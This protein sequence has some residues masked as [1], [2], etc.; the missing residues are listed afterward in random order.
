[1]GMPSWTRYLLTV[2]AIA[3]CASLVVAQDV[4]EGAAP[5]SI[6]AAQD[7]E[8]S[9]APASPPTAEELKAASDAL[10]ANQDI[11]EA[12]RATL[13]D[14]YSKTR[15]QLGKIKDA[16][17]RTARH[18]AGAA[19]AP[20][21]LADVRKKLEAPPRTVEITPDPAAT[22]VDLEAQVK[23][24]NEALA[25][26]RAQARDIEAEPERRTRRRTEIPAELAPLQRELAELPSRPESAAGDTDA[27]TV[28]RGWLLAAQ[29]EALKQRIAAR[30]A[31]L[32]RYD[33]TRDL[34]AAL[35][36]AAQIDTTTAE[37]TAAAW[38]KAVDDRRAEARDA[39]QDAQRLRR[40]AARQHAV[41]QRFA[42]DTEALAATRTGPTGLSRKLADD[43][44]L[45]RDWRD[46]RSRL[47]RGYESIR[48]RL[49]PDSR[50]NRATGLLLRR[51]AEDLPS[52]S[53]LKNSLGRIRK[54]LETA[55]FGLLKSQ[56]DRTD[57]GDVEAHVRQLLEEIRDSDPDAAG[58]EAEAVA[59]ELV[60]A[61]RDL[62]DG[63]VGNWDK[64]FKTLAELEDTTRT[65]IE[66]TKEYD[67]FI[68]ERIL[69]VKSITTDEM[70]T[71]AQTIE[72]FR[73]LVDARS[74]RSTI[75]ASLA[76]AR[77]Y[78]IGH[79][80]AAL[81]TILLILMRMRARRVIIRYA[82]LVSNYRTDKYQY[83]A[84][85]FLLT[86]L[87]A[88]LVPLIMLWAAWFIE[89][90]GQQPRIAQGLGTG[91]RRAA[92]SLFL[93]DVL[94]IS[95]WPKGLAGAHFRWPL[96]P[97]NEIRRNLWWFMILV[98]P[99]AVV[100]TAV[101]EF[102]S[103][104]AVASIGRAMFSVLLILLT[105]LLQ[106]I[107]RP[108]GA[109]VRG[110]AE[111]NPGGIVDRLRYLW[112]GLL[113]ISP[114]VLIAFAW[115]GYL[116]TAQQLVRH[117][118]YSLMFIGLVV[119]FDGLMHRWLFIARRRV[120]VENARRRREEE[121]AAE[122]GEDPAREVPVA[123]TE[124]L[125]LPAISAH[126]KHPF[127]TVLAITVVAGLFCTWR[128]VLP[129]LRMFDR[130]QVYPSFAIVEPPTDGAQLEAIAREPLP[131][132]ETEGERA[133]AAT[134]PGMP[135]PAASP[136]GTTAE[137]EALTITIADLGGAVIVLIVT[138]ILFRNVPG[139]VDII[140]LQRLPLEAGSRY[141]LS[142]VLR[143]SIAIVGVIVAFGS[144]G[145]AWSHVQWLAAALTFGLAFGLQEIFANFV[146]GLIILGEQPFRV[147]DT[148]TVGT[149]SGT[150]TKIKM[151][152]TTIRDW[153]RKEIVIPN[154]TFITGEVVNWTL[155]DPLL[156]LIIEVGV[157]YGSDTPKVTEVLYGVARSHPRVLKDPEPRVHFV[158][159][160]DSTLNFEMRI[161]ISDIDFMLA[162][163]HEV[164]TAIA[165]RFAEEGIEI[166]F[167]Q[168]DLH[169]R[170]IGDL[171]QIVKRE[172]L[173]LGE[174]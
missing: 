26:A 3:V 151:R 171:A 169:V 34:L 99:G 60:T 129:A 83:T 43:A 164:N 64:Y 91:L 150:V 112:T 146:S 40:E 53:L 39:E 138:W 156:R 11:D 86:C 23:L 50:L 19:S 135:A 41:L 48:Q 111:R 165:Q 5:A 127:E 57:M 162:T 35:R 94:R 74:A 13:S 133:P 8:E 108:N 38:Q 131:A 170:S 49:G 75:G 81:G 155:S 145:L 2:G 59:R 61:R 143:Y 1:M 29:R 44:A 21:R 45:L 123:E 55:E 163:R 82:D 68:D 157:A 18:E 116:F 15:E 96:D 139:V 110:I 66:I 161:F 147:G 106:R 14:L 159:F 80:A 32:A 140:V 92:G 153:N 72:G 160:G 105:V 154:K 62:L 6:V 37:Q 71:L 20:Q 76:T 56:Q 28:A 97:V 52:V 31:E 118:V 119:I 136:E 100:A 67:K 122:A 27:I 107:F 4:D 54:D 98:V 137:R 9:P 115:A 121:A 24:A 30:E 172:D 166:A 132:A 173:A 141:A 142:T 117:L 36:D 89:A 109:L 90:P 148:V 84:A 58:A 174:S 79:L 114:I 126:T 46:L 102:G 17:E 87:I 42:A 65:L 78:W 168:R 25:D 22:L 167:P 158:G 144:L 134:V 113:I 88:A 33:A 124:A 149:T 16:A 51:Q 12:T 69:W 152:A 47:R 128:D 10:A 101:V 103:E 104:A 120:A 85:V 77:R 63:L 73:W 70:P 130:M 95:L 125:D 93:L 7:V